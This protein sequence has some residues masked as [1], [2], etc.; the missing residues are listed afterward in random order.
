MA[1]S[2][3]LLALLPIAAAA[4]TEGLRDPTRPLTAAAP[5]AVPDQRG[6]PVLQSLLIGPDR[7]LAVIDGQPMSEGEE[8]RGMKLWEIHA[9]GVVVSVNGSAPMRLS[10]THAGMHKEIR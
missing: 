8:R 10:L 1:F 4:G 5:A 9:N 2:S 6:R 3:L 7:R